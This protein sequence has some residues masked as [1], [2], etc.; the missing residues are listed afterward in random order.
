MIALY[1]CRIVLVFLGFTFPA[2]LLMT[3]RKWLDPVK[4]RVARYWM[5]T[6]F[7]VMI[8]MQCFVTLRIA[9]ENID[10]FKPTQQQAHRTSS[11][12]ISGIQAEDLEA[13]QAN[14]GMWKASFFVCPCR[15][16]SAH[17][18]QPTR[19]EWD[20]ED[21]YQHDREQPQTDVI[22]SSET[23]PVANDVAVEES[24]GG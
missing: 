15:R 12:S 23:G 1:F 17:L 21:V 4:Y 6:V 10:Y 20:S 14:S 8:P 9:I 7:F 22:S 18:E 24:H 19:T 2:M 3:I 13:P 5:Q 11:V 16:G